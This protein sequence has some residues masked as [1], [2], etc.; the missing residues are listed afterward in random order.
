MFLRSFI[1][2]LGQIVILFAISWELTLA[3]LA[4]ILPV[5]AFSVIYGKAMKKN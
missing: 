2:L 4:S 3:M 5:I 1:F